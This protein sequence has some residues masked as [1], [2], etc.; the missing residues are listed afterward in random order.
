MV[1]FGVNSGHLDGWQGIKDIAGVARIDIRRNR[2]ILSSKE[3]SKSNLLSLRLL[4]ESFR[5]VSP[6]VAVVKLS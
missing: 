3:Q 4:D 1:D 6:R 5:C 2:R